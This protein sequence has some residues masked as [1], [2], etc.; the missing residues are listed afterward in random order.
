MNGFER[1][2][3]KFKSDK[4]V[5]TKIKDEIYIQGTQ[6]TWHLVQLA[7][8]DMYKSMELLDYHSMVDAIVER[9]NVFQDDPEYAKDLRDVFDEEVN[10]NKDE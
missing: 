9:L 10:S 8:Y 7:L 1:A 3:T 5:P 2:V 6:Y 4:I